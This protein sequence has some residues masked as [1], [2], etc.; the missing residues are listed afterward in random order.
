MAIL[1][2]SSVDDMQA[3]RAEFERALPE[4]RFLGLDE[5]GG[6]EIDCAVVWE[7]PA[8]LLAS[9]PN[10]RLVFS[11]GAGVDHLF[12]DAA[13]P[14]HVPVV[15]VVDPDLTRQMSEFVLLQVLHHHRRMPEYAAQQ[16]SGEWRVLA[17]R[18]PA[19]ARVGV[20]GLGVLGMDAARR[21]R[22]CGFAVAGWSRSP[23]AEP[24][25][26]CFA[27]A[28]QWKDFLG[29]TEILVCLLPLTPET[30]GILCLETFGAL[31]RPADG[32]PGPVVI[33]P[34]RGAHVREADVL[35]ALDDGTLGGASLDVF[36]EEPLPAEHPLRRRQDVVVTPHI[37]ATTNPAFVAASIRDNLARLQRGEAPGP[38]AHPER[39]Y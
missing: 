32:L 13:F 6:E 26:D 2:H 4:R 8:G 38:L 18:P 22:D 20:M 27:G 19:Q 28:A 17:Q 33:N 24:G 5:C 7:P 1:F 25:I 31:A 9:L 10:L 14:S 29:R 37:A 39:G 3:W 30:R 35:A 23:K 34:G 11:L 36:A 15:R 12:A 16:R 21:L